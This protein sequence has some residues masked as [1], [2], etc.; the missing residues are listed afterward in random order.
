MK[1]KVTKMDEFFIYGYNINTW[2]SYRFNKIEYEHCIIDGYM[3]IP[4]VMF[5]N[6]TEAEQ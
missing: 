3:D 2:Q 1:I 5:T 6:N 4:E